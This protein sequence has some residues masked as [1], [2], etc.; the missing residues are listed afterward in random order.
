MHFVHLALD[1][2]HADALVHR[3]P[4]EVLFV[5]PQFDDHVR[6]RTDHIHDIRRRYRALPIVVYASLTASTLR[7]IVELG[8]RGF[9]D[10]I[11][12]GQDDDPETLRRILDTQPGV[13]MAEL[14]CRRLK[15]R[16]SRCPDGVAAVVEHVLRNPSAFTDVPDIVEQSAIPRRSLYRH[17]DR[18]G[19]AP[20]REI[21]LASRVLRAYALSRIPDMKLEAVAHLTGFAD[22]DALTAAMKWATGTTPA[23]ARDRLA[24]SVVIRAVAD[25]MMRGP[26]TPIVEAPYNPGDGFGGLGDSFGGGLGF[27]AL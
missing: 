15:Q 10:L 26:V 27:D 8:K 19:L 1:W 4:I 14:A 22:A 9:G 11:L 17:L 12:F 25:R 3:K 18:A 24:P 23:R 5:D 13:A 21:L 7:P 16:L 20:P 6:S 2:E